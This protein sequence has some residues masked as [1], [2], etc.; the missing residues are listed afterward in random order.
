MVTFEQLVQRAD[1]KL[2]ADLGEDL[3][4]EVIECTVR[5]AIEGLGFHVNEATG[6]VCDP[7]PKP[8]NNYPYDQ[9]GTRWAGSGRR[10]R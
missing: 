3:T 9:H 10:R 7:R 8:V 5:A 1:A 2:Q 6:E 4:R